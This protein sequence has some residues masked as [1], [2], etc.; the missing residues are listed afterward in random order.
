M[1][2]GAA[3]PLAPSAPSRPLIL[4]AR[5]G[6]AILLALLA[7]AASFDEAVFHDRLTGLNALAGGRAAGH[8]ADLF[9]S[10]RFAAFL[11]GART[12]YDMVSL[13]TPPVLAM[14]DA[15]VI[16]RHADATALAMRLASSPR[17]SMLEAFRLLAEANVPLQ[18]SPS[19]AST[20]PGSTDTTVAPRADTASSASTTGAETRPPHHKPPPCRRRRKP[21]EPV[22]RRRPPWPARARQRRIRR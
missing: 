5:T 3:V 2:D 1:L 6:G 15:R 13:E 21:R 20:P 8:A 22:T 12:R 4:L 11:D 19:V 14:S 10:R 17:G 7:G 9:S 16:G 18:A